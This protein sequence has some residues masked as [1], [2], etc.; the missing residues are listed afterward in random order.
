M[1]DDMNELKSYIEY[2]SIKN[3]VP[4][5]RV[6][7]RLFNLVSYSSD[8][9]ELVLILDYLTSR[10][11]KLKMSYYDIHIKDDLVRYNNKVFSKQEFKA[12][13][14]KYLSNSNYIPLEDLIEISDKI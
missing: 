1:F 4:Y 3:K 12:I 11:I 8:I 9:K 5:K 2:I 14:I 10:L 13:F 6:G 7:E